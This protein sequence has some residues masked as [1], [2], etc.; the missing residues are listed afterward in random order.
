MMGKRLV[1]NHQNLQGFYDFWVIGTKQLLFLGISRHFQAFLGISGSMGN[2][3]TGTRGASRTSCGAQTVREGRE[4]ERG[5][6][7]G[8][9]HL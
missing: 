6:E 8:S 9:S 1:Q 5:G 4:G 3:G 7:G 2:I